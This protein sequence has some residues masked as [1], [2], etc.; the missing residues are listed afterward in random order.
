MGEWW[1]KLDD[2]RYPQNMGPYLPMLRVFSSETYYADIT[3]WIYQLM[4]ILSMLTCPLSPSLLLFPFFSSPL[5]LSISTSFSTNCMKRTRNTPTR[6]LAGDASPAKS[7]CAAFGHQSFQRSIRQWPGTLLFSS[8]LLSSCLLS[9][10]FSNFHSLFHYD[11]SLLSSRLLLLLPTSHPLSQAGTETFTIL[12]K[13]LRML[14]DLHQAREWFYVLAKE[15]GSRALHI[16][17]YPFICFP[18]LFFLFLFVISS[19][20]C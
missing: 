7:Q 11:C 6:D 1:L 5:F 13:A 16:A 8:P 17:L 3:I 14:G 19:Q 12:F 2:N 20:I 15:H 10:S 18:F 9:L 4:R